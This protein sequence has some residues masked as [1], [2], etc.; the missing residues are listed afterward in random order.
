MARDPAVSVLVAVHN[1]ARHLRP[2]LDS[3]LRQTMSDLELVVVDDG[4]TDETP[5]VLESVGD[6]RLRVVRSERRRGLAGALNLGLEE[7]RGRRIARMDADDIAFP[8]W[9][10]TVLARLEGAPRVVLV[11][12]GVLELDAT[13]VFGAVHVPE[14]GPAVTRWHSLFSSSPFFHNTVVLNRE[15]FDRH[16]LRYDESFG[17]SEDYELWTRVLAGAEADVVEEPLVVYRLHP[18]QAS[19]RRAELQRELGQRIALGQIAAAAPGLAEAERE[20]AWRFGFLQELA[21]DELERGAEAYVEL[22]RAY[23]GSGRYA[24]HELEPVRRIAARTVARRAGR[25][26]AGASARLVL[27]ALS[28]DPALAMHVAERRAHRRRAGRRARGIAQEVLRPSPGDHRPIRLV[29]VL[30]EPT[31]YRT[32]MLDRL[33]ERPQ[34][35]LT[36]VYAAR[37][38]QQRAW[39]VDLRHRAVF[40]DGRRVRGAARVLRHDYPLSTGIFRAL[41]DAHPQVVVVSGWSTFASQAAVAWCRRHRVPYV[42]LVESNEREARPGWRRAV[43]SAVVPPVVRGAAEVLVVGSLARESMLARGVPP[44]RISVVAN[45]V[46][47]ARFGREA[48]ELAGRRED[49]RRGVGLEEDDVAVLSVARLAREKGLDTLV[50]A[51]GAAGDTRLVLLLAG[52]GPERERLAS[53]AVELGVRLVL[54]PDVPWERV[55][56]R[57]VL[58]DVFALLSRH[59]PWGVVVNEAAACGLPLVLSDRVGAASDLLEDGRNGA[60]VSVDDVAAAAAALRALAADPAERRA[61][62]AASREIVAPWG[63]EASIENLVG[64]VRR[65]A[66]RQRASAS[67]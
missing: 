65:V 41:R 31:P 13:G 42:L 12:A 67:S 25:A 55:V 16:G 8:H 53:L 30:P 48:G 21:V 4:S 19:K 18:E 14:A 27:R 61:M 40:V 50:R 20:R 22:L 5:A 29:M 26:R 43:K 15:H 59:E 66:R 39:G 1:G 6:A 11:G 35:D 2:A 64:V 60:L 3:V 56:E 63:Y 49:L 9:L 32:G 33:A 7:V 45:T 52:S 36:A 44:E 38:V 51:V 57:Y 28:L 10:A 47:V 23:S 37:A 62:G 17:E 54:L 24:A 58:A 46:D 34:L